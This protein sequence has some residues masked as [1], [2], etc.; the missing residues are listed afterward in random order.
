MIIAYNSVII[1]T[2]S[3]GTPRK[4]F[5]G[6]YLVYTRY[7]HFPWICQIY[8]WYIPIIC[9]PG[10]ILFSSIWMHLMLWWVFAMHRTILSWD[11]EALLGSY[12]RAKITIGYD[13]DI[14]CLYMVYAINTQQWIYSAK[15]VMNLQSCV[16]TC[17]YTSLPGQGTSYHPSKCIFTQHEYLTGIC[18]AYTR[19]ILII[20]HLQP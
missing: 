16:R 8:T 2:R 17:M 5:H 6:I 10:K 13:R 20:S 18:K 1:V 3:S 15:I 11:G 7:I 4:F 12:V 19:H 9:F 14:P